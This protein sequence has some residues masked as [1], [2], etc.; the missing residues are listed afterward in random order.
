MPI[1]KFSPS[2]SGSFKNYTYKETETGEVETDVIVHY[3]MSFGDGY[4]SPFPDDQTEVWAEDEQGNLV[5]YSAD[6]EE[7]WLEM[8]DNGHFE[9]YSE[10]EARLEDAADAKCQ[11]RK[12]DRLV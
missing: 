5:K 9:E 12:E 1:K 11:E 10:Y 6:D 2:D 3:S 8:V 4:G 7:R